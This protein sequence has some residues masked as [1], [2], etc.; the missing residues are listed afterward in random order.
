MENI[1]T[2]TTYLPKP[3]EDLS[4]LSYNQEIK[5]IYVSLF[6]FNTKKNF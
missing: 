6:E 5:N 3:E 2:D 1:S 4:K